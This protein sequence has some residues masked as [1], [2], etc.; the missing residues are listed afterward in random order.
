MVFLW[1]TRRTIIS[2]ATVFSLLVLLL[3]TSSR[4]HTDPY[5]AADASLFHHADLVASYLRT[6]ASDG[7]LDSP[8]VDWSQYAY[9]QYA[10]DLDYLCNAI[11]LFEALDRLGSQA[12]RLLMFP[13]DMLAH[14]PTSLRSAN[15]L[16]T[17]QNKYKVTLEPIDPLNMQRYASEALL[18]DSD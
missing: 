9:L 17:A 12:D 6:L 13:A 7:S 18:L 11:M 16:Q 3:F 15:L 8:A 10:A 4:R 2:L 1:P 14:K 5:R